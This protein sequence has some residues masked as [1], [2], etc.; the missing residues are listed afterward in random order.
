MDKKSSKIFFEDGK[1]I[2][3][4][5]YKLLEKRKE[6]VLLIHHLI[7]IINRVYFLSHPLDLKHIV[8]QNLLS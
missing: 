5:G 4:D 3:T 8:T 7:D 1:D 6:N 2:L